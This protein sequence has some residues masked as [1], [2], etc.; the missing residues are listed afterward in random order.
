MMFTFG[1]L[2]Q[3]STRKNS[4]THSAVRNLLFPAKLE[5]IAKILSCRFSAVST[6]LKHLEAAMIS[7]TEPQD[8]NTF[9]RQRTK[10]R[11]FIVW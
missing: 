6:Q 1:S 5:K 11:G 4:V 8:L 2:R 10:S 7:I 9:M 3:P